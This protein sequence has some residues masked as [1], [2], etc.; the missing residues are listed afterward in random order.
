MTIANSAQAMPDR[1]RLLAIT[2]TMIA[3]KIRTIETRSVILAAQRV[4][5]KAR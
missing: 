3:S 4:V 5:Y 2:P 1:P